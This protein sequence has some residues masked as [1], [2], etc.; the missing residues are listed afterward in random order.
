MI[1]E[2]LLPVAAATATA[3][4]CAALVYY[5]ASPE[6]YWS[7]DFARDSF[8]HI[9]GGALLA[10]ALRIGNGVKAATA[11]AGAALT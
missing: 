1:A 4:I 5:G 6:A 9:V 11:R 7:W 3:L 10:G 8:Y 2:R